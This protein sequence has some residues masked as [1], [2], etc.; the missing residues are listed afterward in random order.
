[1]AALR[2]QGKNKQA[3][4]ALHAIVTVFQADLPSWLEL[5]DIHLCLCDYQVRDSD[6]LLTDC[7]TDWVTAGVTD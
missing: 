6:F 4:E 5:A 7:V 1:M 3:V 2:S